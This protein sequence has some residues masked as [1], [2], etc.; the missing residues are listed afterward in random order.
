MDVDSIADVGTPSAE[1]AADG[2]SDSSERESL[3]AAF[4]RTYRSLL[5]SYFASHWS[6][7]CKPLLRAAFSSIDLLP[8]ILAIGEYVAQRKERKARD[9]A[10]AQQIAADGIDGVSDA[11][12]EAAT[13]VHELLKHAASSY[14][15]ASSSDS[16]QSQSELDSSQTELSSPSSA[17]SVVVVK[18]TRKPSAKQRSVAPEAAQPRH[19]TAVGGKVAFKWRTDRE[20]AL[21]LLQL[22]DCILALD[23]QRVLD[24]T[25]PSYQF[26]IDI[27][28]SSIGPDAP[29]PVKRY[30]VS[31]L[32]PLLSAPRSSLVSNELERTLLSAVTSLLSAPPFPLYSTDLTVGSAEWRDYTSMMDA[33]LDA[34]VRSKAFALLQTLLPKLSEK[35]HAHKVPILRAIRALLIAV[36]EVGKPEQPRQLADDCVRFFMQSDLTDRPRVMARCFMAD[37]VLAPLLRIAPLSVVRSFF[38]AHLMSI[39][40]PIKALE[41]GLPRYSSAE[42][43]EL[44]VSVFECHYALLEVMFQRL[45]KEYFTSLFE[46]LCADSGDKDAIST[47]KILSGAHKHLSVMK[48]VPGL[49]LQ[50]FRLA[51]YATMI[52]ALLAT[53]QQPKFFR[54]L[55]LFA[56][57]GSS[58]GGGG[59]RQDDSQQAWSR[60]IDVQ[61]R[62]T[63]EIDTNFKSIQSGLT[64][65]LAFKQA[66][67]QRGGRVRA[68]E[69]AEDGDDEDWD[70]QYTSASQSEEGMSRYLSSQYLADS[71]LSQ[72]AVDLF[73]S[74]RRSLSS[75]SQADLGSG[76]ASGERRRARVEESSAIA[77]SASVEGGQDVDV[78]LAQ[79]ALPLLLSVLS[80]L[81]EKYG[82]EA[83]DQSQ[84]F[85]FMP[86][87]MEPL[88][89]AMVGEEMEW[90]DSRTLQRA[91][92]WRRIK[93]WKPQPINVR[94]AIAKLLVVKWDIFQP[95]AHFWWRPLVELA[96]L[97]TTTATNGTTSGGVGFHYFLRDICVTLLR[98]DVKPAD[99][100]A[101]RH[102]ASR[103][104]NH[105]LTVSIDH[106]RVPAGKRAKLRSNLQ[107][108][109]LF[110]ASW[111]DLMQIDKQIIVQHL[112]KEIVKGSRTGG[113]ALDVRNVGVQLLAIVVSNGLPAFDPRNDGPADR[114]EEMARALVDTMA[115]E[116]KV[117]YEPAA[118]VYGLVLSSNVKLGRDNVLWMSRLHDFIKR[119]LA[120]QK[121][122]LM[123]DVLVKVA[124]HAHQLG[125]VNGDLADQLCQLPYFANDLQDKTMQLLLWAAPTV[126]DVYDKLRTNGWL[127]RILSGG[128]SRTQELTLLILL[129]QMDAI[130][131]QQLRVLVP[132]LTAAFAS[133]GSDTV[134]E[135]YFK[136]LV[137]LYQQHADTSPLFAVHANDPLVSI[138]TGALV[139][140]L[141]DSSAA[142]RSA[143]FTFFDR[144][145]PADL[146][147]RLL[148]LLTAFH[149]PDTTSVSHW[150]SA[151]VS[152]L[153]QRVFDSADFDRPISDVPLQEC[154]FTV[155]DID[156]DVLSNTLRPFT[157]LFST[158]AQTQ[159]GDS[160]GDET[161]EGDEV[162]ETGMSGAAAAGGL[163]FHTGAKR[164]G[165][166]QLARPRRRHRVVGV[167]ATQTGQFP[168][169][170]SL[171]TMD[172]N[173]LLDYNLSQQSQSEY[174]FFRPT[175]VDNVTAAGS[176]AD[177][178]LTPQQR[179][180]NRRM[181]NKAKGKERGGVKSNTR[182]LLGD[183]VLQMRF[184]A[185]GAA[186]TWN[187]PAASQAHS[188]PSELYPPRIS[189]H[190]ATADAGRFFAAIADRRAREG[191]LLE[192]RMREA[193]RNK[194][195][196]FR[197]YRTGELPDIQIL[198][199]ELLQPVQALHRDAA[200]AKQLFTLIVRALYQQIGKWTASQEEAQA[201]YRQRLAAALYRMLTQLSE[202]PAAF[203]PAASSAVY[204]LQVAMVECARL[205]EQ[206]MAV[207][208]KQSMQP[209]AR[210]S[211]DTNNVHSSILWFEQC[212]RLAQEQE[213]RDA[214]VVGRA[215]ARDRSR[216][217]RGED[218]DMQQQQLAADSSVVQQA[219]LSELCL[220]QLASLYSSL[221]SDDIALQLFSQS[222]HHPLT[223]AALHA[224]LQHNYQ[225]ALDTYD[226]ALDTYEKVLVVADDH[227]TDTAQQAIVDQW[228]RAADAVP[229]EFNRSS[230]MLTTTSSFFSSADPSALHGRSIVP[231]VQ[232]VDLWD[233]ERLDC[234][235]GLTRWSEV[236][237]N[238]TSNVDN[239]LGR[240]FDRESEE[241]RYLDHFLT[242][243]TKSFQR[244]YI[245]YVDE[246]DIDKSQHT[247]SEREQWQR[248]REFVTQSLAIPSRAELLE[249][250]HASQLAL[251]FCFEGERGAASAR[252]F[253]SRCRLNFLQQW[254]QLPP[255]ALHARKRLL[256]Q[257]QTTT[258]VAEFIRVHPQLADPI[259]R[260]SLPLDSTERVL[261]QV[262]LAAAQLARWSARP[263]SVMDN[264]T[265]TWD[266]VLLN[267]ASFLHSLSQYIHSTLLPPL[268]TQ[269][270]HKLRQG[271]AASFT[272]DA[273]AAVCRLYSKAAFVQAAADNFNVANKYVQT[274]EAVRRTAHSKDKALDTLMAHQQTKLSVRQCRHE[275]DKLMSDESA[276]P[277]RDDGTEQK[278][279]IDKQKFAQREAK[280]TTELTTLLADVAAAQTKLGMDSAEAQAAEPTTAYRLLSL[281][282]D[283]NLQLADITAHSLSRRNTHANR[284]QPSYAADA[285]DD[286]TT[287]SSLFA[288]VAV[289]TVN[290]RVASSS[291]AL[292]ILTSAASLKKASK[293]F[294]SVATYAN[295][296]LSAA[297]AAQSSELQQ[298]SWMSSPTANNSAPSASSSR[299]S[300]ELESH[301]IDLFVRNVLYGMRLNQRP[302]R[303]L[304]PRALDVVSRCAVSS[305]CRHQ[306]QLMTAGQCDGRGTRKQHQDCTCVSM[307]SIFPSA[308]TRGSS[309]IPVWQFI[310]WIPQLLST[311]GSPEYAL[312]S[313]ILRLLAQSYPQAVYFPFHLRR[314]VQRD[315]LR[316]EAVGSPAAALAT[317]DAQLA[318]LA[319][320]LP[321]RLVPL[322]LDALDS[323]QPPDILFNDMWKEFLDVANKAPH[324]A[325]EVY[326]AYKERRLSSTSRKEA[327]TVM[328]PM[329][330]VFARKYKHK[331]ETLFAELTKA[332]STSGVQVKAILPEMNKLKEAMASD[333]DVGSRVLL[334][335]QSLTTFSRWL[336]DF[337]QHAAAMHETLEIPGQ[338]SSD[339][340]PLPSQHTHIVGFSR[341]VLVLSSLRKPKR[342]TLLGS[343][344][345]EYKMMIKGGE[346]LRADE[347]IE[348]LFRA[349]NNILAADR[350]T[351]AAEFSLLTY[352][353]V[354]LTSKLG[355]IEWLPDTQSVKELFRQQAGDDLMKA[356]S[357]AMAQYVSELCSSEAQKQTDAAKHRD[358]LEKV[359][360]EKVVRKFS[361]LLD[362]LPS[363][364]FARAF[365]SLSSCNEAFLVLRSR[366]ARSF[367]VMSMS[368]YVLGIGD[369]HCDNFL[370]DRSSGQLAAIDFGAAFGQGTLLAVP[371]LMPIRL[372]RQFQNILS[373]LHST[374]LM[375]GDMQAVMASYHSQQQQI[376]TLLDVF[377]KDPPIEWVDMA[378]KKEQDRQAAQAT[379]QPQPASQSE[380]SKSATPP[381]HS[382]PNSAAASSAAAQLSWFPLR[383]VAYSR[384]KLN[385]ANPAAVLREEMADNSQFRGA[386]GPA[387]HEGC[388]R[389]VDGSDCGSRRSKVGHYCGGVEEQVD[390]IIEHATDLNVLGR[391]W[392]GWAPHW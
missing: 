288:P 217:A 346:D 23:S 237:E 252:Q 94:W 70:S 359:S 5:N 353:V 93:D 110:V 145:L 170:Q 103:F 193:Q 166:G 22:L 368:Q 320:H 261:A 352:S 192:Q 371:E 268:A 319:A 16:Q 77:S 247:E 228:K 41:E 122:S 345:K 266:D 98:W 383:K 118:E 184:R 286:L 204:A 11:D 81:D 213:A 153:L 260:R 358:I 202:L 106:G 149:R 284:P 143:L 14:F 216:K 336:P 66:S 206:A 303:L 316:S 120:E 235:R 387:L 49:Q 221:G 4:Y 99:T 188:Q 310:Q 185:Y 385:F 45:S 47:K 244:T 161:M 223:R 130:S 255:L 114:E 337:H 167:R 195:N 341:E 72:D 231:S 355:W 240:L 132:E 334:G 159:D 115:S 95:W 183:D 154:K 107:I 332:K 279:S 158:N 300:A 287:L 150:L 201:E 147:E 309:I 226:K 318:P 347:R 1:S 241:H 292:R 356:S 203:V 296:R 176:I 376:L 242:A 39:W 65:L 173:Q 357:T 178:Q 254:E 315:K 55:V 321:S 68:A 28:T 369:R 295:S 377:V 364:L 69:R 59:D 194:V 220:L 384:A 164:D 271:M 280:L 278:E 354:P 329:H 199:R 100:A 276:A 135:L 91:K 133:H 375:A 243:S 224:S 3:S 18:S 283:V 6:E 35:Q 392:Q 298:A 30:A 58:G 44:E 330:A 366:L 123:L 9:R 10:V 151:V 138:V 313:P 33:L 323:L 250:G 88:W 182:V 382:S 124:Q 200:M 54:T 116:R 342:L 113:G 325:A 198:H 339:S 74:D 248:L 146:P 246:Q 171:L 372:T 197:S 343:D 299:L 270:H 179:L 210:L 365:L 56:A 282:A 84:N 174:L 108:V 36:N 20:L 350:R 50:P 139:C 127:N 37:S 378:R 34:M 348:Q 304:F 155:M 105:L 340:E 306:F 2:S 165:G 8:L 273:T 156:A 275:L 148:E 160:D 277:G 15:H 180:A 87:W 258:E 363:D 40:L 83:R 134:R 43:A 335:H 137:Y 379:A 97:P 290:T 51:A 85:R 101:E 177:Y 245:G 71:S 73:A 317:L 32:P 274:A 390:L 322:L 265:S 263:P 186:Q 232:E 48:D 262:T 102:L 89:Q 307:S 239:E 208:D 140:G 96:L 157:P 46:R 12:A 264:L 169:T 205:D 314:D 62:W 82:R 360:A 328:A 76:E 327:H 86:V 61:A 121:W 17:D 272:S 386:R 215:G 230:S 362:I 285:I 207:V 391:T 172:V 129:R 57:H 112:K 31:L 301:L 373:P 119:Q 126:R 92:G 331:I 361:P 191:R 338:Y 67:R 256:R 225:Q 212:L 63:F 351:A 312:A 78:V 380:S 294:L 253:L 311:V 229:P 7:Y 142:L 370:L 27:V 281:K 222:A 136:L 218:V 190:E 52:A 381:Q 305:E 38:D 80:W 291:S 141:N 152:L 109:R 249:S 60:I 211:L 324:R 297:D 111:K 26:F 349:M 233:R 144:Q 267:R 90:E 388:V 168:L 219:S 344:E 234:L 227:K 21:Q 259:H 326:K 131:L 104:V 175:D 25:Q 19:T 257:L 214:R 163:A 42:A 181:R 302:A 209:L 238:V 64:D 187:E 53:Q 13:F 24:S 236:R 293:A 374:R 196:L 75:Q 389:V 308:S 79:P 128:E 189:P 117:L 289:H 251:L 333:K 29:L 367:A 125:L 269:P 162:P